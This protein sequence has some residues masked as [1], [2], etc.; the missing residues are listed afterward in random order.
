[1][2]EKRD[3]FSLNRNGSSSLISNFPIQPTNSILSFGYDENEIYIE[4]NYQKE[5][6]ILNNIDY[7]SLI[8][9]YSQ[10]YISYSAFSKKNPST[11]NLVEINNNKEESFEIDFP[12][13]HYNNISNNN[14]LSHNNNNYNNNI[15][16]ININNLELEERLNLRKKLKI[17]CICLIA[18]VIVIIIKRNF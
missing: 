14:N 2:L 9:K 6:Q 5:I 11:R 4:N 15:N 12:N 1:M 3:V 16:Y 10:S 8:K 13:N 18:F 7:V 17:V